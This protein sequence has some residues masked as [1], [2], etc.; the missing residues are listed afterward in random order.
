MRTTQVPREQN[1]VAASYMSFID[2]SERCSSLCR[3]LSTT[4]NA[5]CYNSMAGYWTIPG[6]ICT[7]GINTAAQHQATSC[8]HAIRTISSCSWARRCGRYLEHYRRPA[9]RPLARLVAPHLAP[10]LRVLRPLRPLR[11]LLPRLFDPCS[12]EHG[13]GERHPP[14]IT[15]YFPRSSATGLGGILPP[16]SPTGSSQH[17]G[18]PVRIDRIT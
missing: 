2:R 17:G 4:H 14:F 5:T 10:L 1:R 13:P 6:C 3:P 16:R 7:G 9:S 15:S 8:L 11:P 12:A 18:I